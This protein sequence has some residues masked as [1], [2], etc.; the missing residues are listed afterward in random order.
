MHAD[1]AHVV[2]QYQQHG[3]CSNLVTLL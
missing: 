3:T 1:N 2:N